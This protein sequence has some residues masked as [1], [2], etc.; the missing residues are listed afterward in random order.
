VDLSSADLGRRE[1]IDADHKAGGPD[2]DRPAPC[3]WRATVVTDLFT[4]RRQCAQRPRLRGG[5]PRRR[6]WRAQI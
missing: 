6:S 3:R 4:K 5:R 1:S 2:L